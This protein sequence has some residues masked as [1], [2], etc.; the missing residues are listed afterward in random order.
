MNPFF[1][2]GQTVLFQGD[3]ITDWG[4]N[5]DDITSLSTGYAGKVATIYNALFP[6]NHITFINKGVSGDR[7]AEVLNRYEEDFKQIKPDFVSILVGINDT[8]RRYD[9]NDPTTTE[10]FEANY[11]QILENLKRDFPETKIMLMEP[12]VFDSLPERSGWRVDLGPKIEVVRKLAREYADYFLP[13]DGIFASLCTST[14]EPSQIT[15][16]G[17]H[18]LDLG[19]SIIA[20]EYLKLL[21]I[22]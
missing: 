21:Q 8:W 22:I 1:K 9:N 16:D 15:A 5:R 12:Y 11:R 2:D 20:Y 3:S 4:R 13:L 17:V 10:Q 18:P 6:N 7:S 19:H 14:Y